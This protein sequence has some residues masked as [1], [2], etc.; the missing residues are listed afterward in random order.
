[1][2]VQCVPP[3]LFA[4]RISRTNVAPSSKHEPVFTMLGSV[5]VLCL[6]FLTLGQARS[7]LC[8]V[9]SLCS[10]HLV[11]A[12]HLVD[13]RGPLE[14]ARPNLC[15]VFSVSLLCVSFNPRAST[16]QSVPCRLSVFIPSRWY[17]AWT[18]VA[19]SSKHDPLFTIYVLSVFLTS[20]PCSFSVFLPSRLLHASRGQTWLP[21]AS[22]NQ[23]LPCRFSQSLL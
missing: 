22:T 4:P 9:L 12:T 3:I 14:Q 5:I 21:R 19:P 1:M 7:H 11:C 10:S 2:V 13:K 15:H 20:V 23:S 8:H 17:H 16:I 6:F 18:N